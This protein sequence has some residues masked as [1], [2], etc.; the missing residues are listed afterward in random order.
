MVICIMVLELMHVRL[1]GLTDFCSLV[2]SLAWL[3]LAHC[4]DQSGSSGA[5][6]VLAAASCASCAAVGLLG[7][8]RNLVSS[9]RPWQK[10]PF[11]RF[12]GL[13]EFLVL[14]LSHLHGL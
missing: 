9:Q 4:P 5:A 3:F 2:R 10:W 11:P 6:D 7:L 13:G 12:Q 8:L 1:E 14:S